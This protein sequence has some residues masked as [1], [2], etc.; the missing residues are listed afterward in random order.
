MI[1]GLVTL[2]KQSDN[3]KKMV[4]LL[5]PVLLGLIA[6]IFGSTML[7]FKLNQQT[8]VSSGSLIDMNG[9]V[10]KTA[11]A[12]EGYDIVSH[13]LSAE[14]LS[15]EALT[16]TYFTIDV[17]GV[18]QTP[19]VDGNVVSSL[20]M[21]EYFTLNVDGTDRNNVQLSMNIVDAHKN[22]AIPNL[23]AQQLGI[24]SVS[25]VEKIVTPQDAF[26]VKKTCAKCY[27]GTS[28]NTSTGRC[29]PIISKS[30]QTSSSC[31]LRDSFG[32]CCPSSCKA[33]CGGSCCSC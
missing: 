28:C 29:D 4:W 21:T 7:A 24:T 1:Q 12:T 17:K 22:S 3:Y 20:I 26:E 10:V 13:A 11:A 16:S 19:D 14:G 25:N 33:K 30:G 31:Y 27:S 9:S 6:A 15:I 5:I 32:R 23:F 18:I 2:Q 8:Q